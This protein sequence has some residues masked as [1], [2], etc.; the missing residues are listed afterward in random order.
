MVYNYTCMVNI[1]S[2]KNDII[3]DVDAQRQ[4][5]FDLSTNLHDNP[6]LGYEEVKA[7]GWL[8]EYLEKNDFHLEHGICS[9]PTAFIA[10]YGGGKPVIAFLAEYDALPEVGH[11]CG[12]NLIAAAAVGAATAAKNAVELLGGTI[13]VI[14]TPAEELSGGKLAMVEEGIFNN[15]DAAMLT[16]PGMHNTATI[17]ALAAIAI[18]VEF[19]GRESHASA[20][21]E[22]GINALDAMIQAFNAINSLRQH[23]TAQQRVH[24]IIKDGGKAANVIPAHSSADFLIRAASLTEL[25]ELKNK[26]FDCFIGAAKATGATLKYKWGDYAYAPMKNNETLANLF[27]NNINLLGN[28]MVLCDKNEKFGSTDMGNVS[29]ITPA[30]HPIVSI[31]SLPL[32]FHTPQFA[33]TAAS[34]EAFQESLNAAKAMAMTATDLLANSSTLDKVRAEFTSNTR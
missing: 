2:L 4:L 20:S 31:T 29:Q 34:E 24:G 10:S 23:L 14:G 12:H 18:D 21:P 27:L 11:A 3:D 25:E 9:M 6:E 26:V 28:P 8:S 5:L 16:H 30:I 22:G 13:Q 19:I 1:S 7:A 33:R 17:R 15:V 32:N